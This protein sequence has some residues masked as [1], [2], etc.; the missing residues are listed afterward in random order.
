M[1]EPAVVLSELN[2]VPRRLVDAYVADQGDT[3]SLF[4]RTLG[5]M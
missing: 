1:H 5:V 4:H 2:E 3:G